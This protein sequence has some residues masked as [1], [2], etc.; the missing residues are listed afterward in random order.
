MVAKNIDNFKNTSDPIK[1][2]KPQL[3]HLFEMFEYVY[4]LHDKMNKYY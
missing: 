1:I 3:N 4:K 2:N